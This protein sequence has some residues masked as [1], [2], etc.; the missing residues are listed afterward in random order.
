MSLFRVLL[1]IHLIGVISWMAGILYLIR[2]FVY[3]AGETE[4]V[5]KERFK[6]MEMR[7]Y[8]MIT[9]PAMGLAI[10]MGL[11]MILLSPGLLGER[12]FQ[13]KLVLGISLAL[14]TFACGRFVRQFF[15]GHVNKHPRYFR[16]LNEIPTLIMIVIVLLAILRPS[17]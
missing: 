9:L 5:V 15:I 3:H 12:W 1:A 13:F 14:I 7:L 2:L 4:N 10:G 17:R 16:I 11:A 6:L 8:R